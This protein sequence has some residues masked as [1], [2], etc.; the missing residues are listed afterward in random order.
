MLYE[1]TFPLFLLKFDFLSTERYGMHNS[2]LLEE[3]IKFFE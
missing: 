3:Y 1:E 2:L